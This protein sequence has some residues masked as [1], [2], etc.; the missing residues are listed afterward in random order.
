MKLTGDVTLLQSQWIGGNVW[1][2]QLVDYFVLYK[3]RFFHSLQYSAYSTQCNR[4]FIYVAP[5]QGIYSEVPSALAKIMSKW[6][7]SDK[8]ANMANDMHCIIYTYLWSD[9]HQG[10]LPS[11]LIMHIAYSPLFLKKIINYPPSFVLFQLFFASTPTLTMMHLC[12][13]LFK[14]TRRPW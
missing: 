2:A 5:L 3:I 12:I 1:S 9:N 8:S 6:C 13:M 10:H 11:K 14:R 4:I 7:S